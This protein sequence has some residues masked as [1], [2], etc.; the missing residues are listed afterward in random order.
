MEKQTDKQLEDEIERLRK[1]RDSDLKQ[2]RH[3]SAQK[4]QRLIYL[5]EAELKG[6]KEARQGMIK[7]EDVNKMIDE[8]KWLEQEPLVSNRVRHIERHLTA[9]HNNQLD[10]LKQSLKEL[11]EKQ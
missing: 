4:N 6:R 10:E 8:K 9:V 7:I 5:L 3:L 2:L 1:N 11:W